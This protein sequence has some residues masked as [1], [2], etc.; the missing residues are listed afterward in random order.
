MSK[1]YDDEI[2]IF[3]INRK[4]KDNEYEEYTVDVADIYEEEQ[5]EKKNKKKRKKKKKK[6][7]IAILIGELLVIAVLIFTLVMLIMPN[8][9]AWL[10]STPIGKFFISLVMSEDEYN[11]IFDDEFNRDVETNDGLDTDAMKDY[12]NIALIGV[13][14][15][16]EQLESWANSDTIIVCSINKKSGEVKLASVYRDTCMRIT[17]DD[18][19][20]TY[21]KVN[22]AYESK[23]GAQNL[24][25]TLNTNLDLNI[26]DYVTI[27]FSCLA[28]VIDMLGGIDINLSE[29]EVYWINQYLTETRKI[30]GMSSP[31]VYGSGY[32]HLNGLQATAFCR[33]RYATFKDID[34]QEYRDDY[35][36]TARQRRVIQLMV[37]KAKSAGVSE[38][39][40]IAEEIFNSDQKL[41]YTSIPYDEIIDLIPTL[42]E[43]SIV[44]TVG[45]PF[46]KEAYNEAG[47]VSS[48]VCIA[49]LT[50]NNYKLHEFLFD[51][52]KYSPSQ[53]VSDLNDVLFSKFGC[54]EKRLEGDENLKID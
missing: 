29:D 2:E 49:G 50:Y 38:V 17:K 26:S 33:I 27:N 16:N 10:L 14:T 13:D 25:N 42:M 44:G 52:K 18:G 4:S 31:D 8:S 1:Q 30:T 34:G 54:P 3:D 21:N 46:T 28:N 32:L 45:Y 22:S 6:G 35:G 9:K 47:G 40:D 15:R 7:K 24:V 48:P 5:K 53:T 20:M 19:D 43:F 36:R 39:M 37:E 12:Y 23:K 11:N 41:I 51:N